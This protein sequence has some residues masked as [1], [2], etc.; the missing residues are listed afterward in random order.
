M[1]EG[2]S[3]SSLTRNNSQNTENRR[4][5]SAGRKKAP[6][7][8]VEEEALFKPL[9]EPKLERGTYWQNPRKKPLPEP[10]KITTFVG[11]RVGTFVGNPAEMTAEPVLEPTETPQG[12]PTGRQTLRYQ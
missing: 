7:T 12:D 5:P 9:P 6:E 3:I 2:V 10:A 1:P 11:I 4:V 8:R